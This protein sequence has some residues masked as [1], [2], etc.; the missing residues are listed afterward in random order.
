[1]NS[2]V[3]S[4]NLKR[5]EQIEKDSLTKLPNFKIDCRQ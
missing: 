1:M 2:G 3:H 5:S 4:D